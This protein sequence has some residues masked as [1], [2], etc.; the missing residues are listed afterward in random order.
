LFDKREHEKK[1]DAQREMDR[2]VRD[3]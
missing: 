1:R 2:A 3:R